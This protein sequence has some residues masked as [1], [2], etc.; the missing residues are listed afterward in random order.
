MRSGLLLVALIS[1][2]GMPYQVLMPV[3]ATDVLGGGAH[4]LGMLMTAT[5][6]GALAG[7]LYLAARPSVVGLGRHIARAA[8]AFGLAL[9]VFSVSRSLWLSLLVLPL[10][11]AGFMITLAATN[12]I[13]QTLVP[14]HLRGRVMAFYTMAFLGTAPIGSLIAGLAAERIGVTRT[15]AAGGVACL[16]GGIWFYVNLPKFRELV[17]PIYI[18]KGLL[19]VPD[20][21][22]GQKT[23]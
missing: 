2:L 6:L 17:R 18:E 12:T 15:I 11:G 10:S 13:V 14:E 1:T 23:L 9:L 4:T 19:S 22:T 8:I 21:D 3:M 7:T 5:G 16:A 20:A